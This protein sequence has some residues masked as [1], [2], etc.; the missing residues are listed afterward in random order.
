MK[1]RNEFETLQHKNT[2]LQETL[3][4]SH[5]KVYVMN[6]KIE[7]M[8]EKLQQTTDYPKLK[9]KAL[10]KDREI[11]FLKRSLDEARNDKNSLNIQHRKDMKDLIDKFLKGTPETA[12]LEQQI[13]S[14]REEFLEKEKELKLKC[15]EVTKR[16]QEESLKNRELLHMYEECLL[17]NKALKREIGDLKNARNTVFQSQSSYSRSLR[18]FEYKMKHSIPVYQPFTSKTNEV[19]ELHKKQGEIQTFG[20]DQAVSVPGVIS[21]DQTVIADDKLAS[22]ERAQVSEDWT[23]FER[24]ERESAALENMYHNFRASNI[25]RFTREGDFEKP[26]VNDFKP[27]QKYEST[28]KQDFSKVFQEASKNS[29]SEVALEK[30]YRSTSASGV[31]GYPKEIGHVHYRDNARDYQEGNMFTNNMPQKDEVL[32]DNQNAHHL[33]EQLLKSAIGE[34]DNGDRLR[35][36]DTKSDVLNS[37]NSFDKTNAEVTKE[38]AKPSLGVVV[39]SDHVHLV[40]QGWEGAEAISSLGKIMDSENALENNARDFEKVMVTTEEVEKSA[41]A[42]DYRNESTREQDEDEKR[43]KGLDNLEGFDGRSSGS[44]NDSQSVEE[45]YKEKEV[46]VESKSYVVEPNKTDNKDIE[47]NS[48]KKE[49]NEDKIVDKDGG[50]DIFVKNGRNEDEN[51]E[52]FENAE[53][54]HIDPLMKHYMEMVMKTKNIVEKESEKERLNLTDDTKIESKLS[55][56]DI[57]DLV[58]D[59]IEEIQT[60]SPDEFDW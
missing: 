48:T 1:Y 30:K 40:K 53:D 39:N 31:S 5:Q 41:A 3:H 28:L 32:L 6:Q 19:A 43:A 22:N 26:N 29:M 54:D 55:R 60:G 50:A 44:K 47:N 8:K 57:S 52:N 7:D 4:S 27:L 33:T 11:E 2:Q 46:S 20:I 23:T 38:I 13:L 18:P 16:L 37:R 15:R 17:Q 42:K 24:L 25:D 9:E 21:P 45:R 36:F 10:L 35:T 14:E 58:E 49:I 51:Q 59:K 34:S 12:K 56:S